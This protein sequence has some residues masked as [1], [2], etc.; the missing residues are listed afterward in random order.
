MAKKILPELDPSRDLAVLKSNV[1]FT[2]SF[3]TTVSGATIS[4]GDL[5]T[6][7]SD[8]PSHT[9]TSIPPYAINI[10]DIDNSSL[11]GIS[12]SGNSLTA[13]DVS[14]YKNLTDLNVGSNLLPRSEVS[15]MLVALDNNDQ[16]NG[17]LSAIDNISGSITADAVVS[18]NSLSQKG[19]DLDSRESYGIWT[20]SNISTVAWY[21]ASDS[22]S[23]TL[24]GSNVTQWSDKNGIYDLSQ[25]TVNDQPKY[26][27]GTI[28]GL[29]AIEFQDRSIGSLSQDM[30]VTT[31]LPTFEYVIVIMNRTFGD[32]FSQAIGSATGAGGNNYT[33]QYRGD[34]ATNKWQNA[35][36]TDGNPL[37]S[38]GADAL[39]NDACIVVHDGLS[40]TNFPL[41]VGGDRGLNSRGWDGFIGEIICGSETL[42][43]EL[44]QK[45][46][47]YL[48][49]KWGLTAN[50]PSNHPYKSVAP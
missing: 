3:T 46:E 26:G 15:K 10:K 2:G 6:E 44:R 42:T 47:G 27:T 36:Y 21:D 31:N 18:Y 7:T 22:D 9:Y 20:P 17:T 16:E 49:H 19:W 43:T 29:N 8:T 28:N 45:V 4:Y 25:G 41:M 14:K 12:I 35:Y 23:I 32:A 50:L 33:V 24:D 1:T 5:T 13:V 38:T 48:A 37:S 30:S 11:T 40:L 39:Y 34:V